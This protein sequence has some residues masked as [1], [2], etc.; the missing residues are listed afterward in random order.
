LNF[1][2]ASSNKFG[3]ASLENGGITESETLTI[4]KDEEDLKES[5]K[6]KNWGG[7]NVSFRYENYYLL[8]ESIEIK[9]R[10]ASLGNKR[11]EYIQFKKIFIE[12]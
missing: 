3:H 9:D 5:E 4:V 6:L 7:A 2:Y 10:D 12:Q 1:Y 8:T 11:K